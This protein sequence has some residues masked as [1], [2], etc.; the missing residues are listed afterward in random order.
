MRHLIITELILLT[1][2]AWIPIGLPGG[3]PEGHLETAMYPMH[4][5]RFRIPRR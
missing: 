5:L 1:R 4:L 3:Y 2:M